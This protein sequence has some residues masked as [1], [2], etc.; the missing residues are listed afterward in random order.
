MDTVD[1][2]IPL[3]IKLPQLMTPIEAQS[4]ALSLQQQMAQAQLSQQQVQVGQNTLRDQVLLSDFA[5]QPGSIDPATGMWTPTALA[6]ITQ[7][8][9][10]LGQKLTQAQTAEQYKLSQIELEKGKAFVEKQKAVSGFLN[11]TFT[12]ALR[13]AE[14]ETDPT[15]REEKFQE[16]YANSFEEGKK[17][18]ILGDMIRKPITYEQAKK[19]AIASGAASKDPVQLALAGQQAIGE[20]KVELTH[21][22]VGSPEAQAI[23]Q[24]IAIATSALGKQTG[25]LVEET[26]LTKDA[27]KIEQLRVRSTDQTLPAAERDRAAREMKIIEE[28]MPKN[29]RQI[30][31]VR[32]GEEAES[33]KLAP[34]DLNFMARQAWAG[35]TSVFTNIGRGRQGASNIAALRHEIQKVGKEMGK[36]P[37]DLAMA[38]A[39]FFGTKA[40]ERTLGTRQAQINLASNVLEQFVPLANAASD[41]YK[42]LDIKNVNDMQKAIQSKTASPE[43]RRANA[44]TNAVIN[45]YSRAI[46]PTGVPTDSD[47]AHA[48]EILDIAFANGDFKAATDQMML[49]IGAEKKAPGAVKAAM[50]EQVTGKPAVAPKG[51]PTGSKSIGKSPEGK[52]VWQ[53]PDGKKWVE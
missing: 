6:K 39:E 22:P 49:E 38:N 46:S 25:A 45:A 5:L 1:A 29:L 41:A 31:N 24:K 18:G 35:D 9:P 7:A 51:I 27:R 21:H 44:A 13:V 28:N 48:R 52:T 36:T 40:G 42:R 47:K 3:G 4:N 32:M 15:K 33:A 10:L 2:R 53:S 26:P 20:L 30:T 16:A 8:S 17:G 37:E 43:L 23:A 11:D 12:D 14:Q 19:I 50:R 34:D